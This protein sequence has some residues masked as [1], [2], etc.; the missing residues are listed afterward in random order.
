MHIW[1]LNIINPEA[2]VCVCTVQYSTS[3]SLNT[4]ETAYSIVINGLYGANK[5]WDRIT[6]TSSSLDNKLIVIR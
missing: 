5:L 6:A 4:E 1:S 2:R 3:L